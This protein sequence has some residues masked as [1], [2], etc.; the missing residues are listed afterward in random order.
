MTHARIR[1][2]DLLKGS[3]GGEAD[4]SGNTSRKLHLAYT[5]KSGCPGTFV[6]STNFLTLCVFPLKRMSKPL[7]RHFKE[8]SVPLHYDKCA[9]QVCCAHVWHKTCIRCAV[10]VQ[11]GE[12]A[13]LL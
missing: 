6:C 8:S 12:A 1:Q 4:A 13:H 10:P 2:R 5:L 9:L 11:R 7:R 3:I